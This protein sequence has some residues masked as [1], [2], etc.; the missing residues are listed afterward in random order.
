M[1]ELPE[2]GQSPPEMPHRELSEHVRRA[3]GRATTVVL[4]A[5]GIGVVTLQA[6]AGASTGTAAARPASGAATRTVVRP[7][8]SGPIAYDQ[9]TQFLTA[10]PTSGMPESCVSR[11]M[12]LNTDRVSGTGLPGTRH[13]SSCVRRSGL[14]TGAP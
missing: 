4:V 13:G 8:Y 1:N 12:T 14:L 3:S 9:K 11:P 10:N 5:A 2:T 6:P 7:N